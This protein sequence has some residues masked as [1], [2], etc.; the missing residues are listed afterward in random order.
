MKFAFCIGNGES[1]KGFDISKLS[2]HG[3][4]YGANAIFR[5]YTVD[6]LVCC[7]RQMAMECT[8]NNYTG[9]V[10]TRKDWY[11]FFPYNNFKCLPPLPWEEKQ[12]WTQS[13]HMGSG[14]HAVNLATLTGADIVVIIG[15][16]FWDTNGKHNNVY[17]GTENY[18]AADHQAIDPSFWIKQFKMF[19]ELYPKKQFVFVQ[20]NVKQWRKPEEWNEVPNLQ[21]EELGGLLNAL[22]QS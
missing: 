12:K 7:D 14:L 18:W 16:D 10:Y 19:F 13:F 15:H 17:K 9:L 6:H 20:R 2:R 3:T 5:D 1:R 11:S 4:V 21:Y 8:K 22:D